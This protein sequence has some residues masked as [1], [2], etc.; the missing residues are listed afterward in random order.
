MKPDATI[1]EVANTWLQRAVQRS[2]TLV[3]G[4]NTLSIRYHQL[5]ETEKSEP[6]LRQIISMVDCF[7]AMIEAEAD[8]IKNSKVLI[9]GTSFTASQP[10]YPD[11]LT[12]AISGIDV[13]TVAATELE[14]SVA[15]FQRWD[16]QEVITLDLRQAL[17][18][19]G[20]AVLACTCFPIASPK[21]EILFPDVEFLDPGAYGARLL[22]FDHFTQNRKLDLKVTG[23]VVSQASVAGFAENYL[24]I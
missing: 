21:L 2:E 1:A 20:F 15:R 9:I 24:F 7:K 18:G 23:E 5:H 22:N 8:R 12:D 10:L 3:V 6:G 14:R 17:E 19:A 16:E 13:S 4:C 11:L